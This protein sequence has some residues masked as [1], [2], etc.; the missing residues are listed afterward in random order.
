MALYQQTPTLVAHVIDRLP[1]GGAERLVV[2]VKKN[3]YDTFEH[4]V[5]CLVAVGPLG[6]GLEDIGVPVIIFGKKGK[7]DISLFFRLYRW[8][9]SEQPAVV[10]T[11]LFTVDS[12]G[13]VAT[14]WLVFLVFQ[15]SS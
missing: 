1:P 5:L 7:F 14:Y 6:E 15:Y 13:R 12:W 11:H 2:D 4:I 9:R 8:F 3:R 10:H